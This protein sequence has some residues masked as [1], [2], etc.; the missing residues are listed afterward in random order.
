MY[1]MS[2]TRFV[3]QGTS[4][5]QHK[6]LYFRS[7]INLCRMSL[8]KPP[9]GFDGYPVE[10][11]HIQQKCHTQGGKIVEISH[12]KHKKYDKILHRRDISSTIQRSEF[13]KFRQDWWKSKV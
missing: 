4:I 2:Y 7:P 8:G 6:K 3:F 9:I 1:M 5:F 12:T 13:K 10:L 11:H